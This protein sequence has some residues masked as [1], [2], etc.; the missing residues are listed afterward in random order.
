VTSRRLD[1]HFA[2]ACLVLIASS[3]H[4]DMG[5]E[6]QPRALTAQEKEAAERLGERLRK[7]LPPAP[8]GWKTRDERV[9][10]QAGSCPA[11]GNA[12]QIPQ[13]VTV[14]VLRNYVMEDPPK[15]APAAAAEPRPSAP[16]ARP[17]QE[18]RIPALEKQ[19]AEF[20][21]QEVE[22]TA[23][24]QAARRSGD[25]AAQ[26]AAIDA[27]RKLRAEMAPVQRELADLRRAEH[28]ERAA[29]GAARTQA[30]QARMAEERRNLRNALVSI[31][32]N[33]T[34]AETRGAR[35]VSVKDVPLALRD[36]GGGTHLFLGHW[37][38]S[39]TFAMAK[40]DESVPT[41]RVQSIRVRIEGNEGAAAELL[42]R[43]DLK[44]LA[45]LVE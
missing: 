21:R 19:V 13:P 5:R 27:S 15:Q 43:F 1:P 35:P 11:E 17:E 40:I 2:F 38:R 42:E 36:G 4:A 24:Y 12:R 25:S 7:A 16:A 14:S 26:R 8:A 30:T 32:T 23:A 34:Q 29:A 3:A 33:L 18:A 44:A 41:T 39:G 6:C 9:D 37:R 22:L 10:A 20:K 45:S 31:Q 28:G